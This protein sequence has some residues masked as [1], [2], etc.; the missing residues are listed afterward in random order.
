V[1]I[2]TTTVQGET[3]DISEYAS[4]QRWLSGA[5]HDR[6]PAEVQDRYLGVLATF[7]EHTGKSPDEL[8][9]FCFLRK[10]ETGERFVSTKRRIVVNEWIDELVAAQGWTGKD[11]VANANIVRSFLIHNGVLIQGKVWKG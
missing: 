2:D 1:S 6:Q 7:V 3:V 8:V 9:A 4:V 11:A 5:G 10:R